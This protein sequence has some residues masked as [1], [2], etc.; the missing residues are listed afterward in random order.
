MRLQFS[1]A[2]RDG[3]CGAPLTGTRRRIL[4]VQLAGQAVGG[5]KVGRPSS[6]CEDAAGRHRWLKRSLARWWPRLP[7]LQKF[8]K[9]L[10][11]TRLRNGL[12]LGAT[13]SRNE[14]PEIRLHRRDVRIAGRC[15]PLLRRLEAFPAFDGD[16]E[17]DLAPF[18]IVRRLADFLDP[19]Q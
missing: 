15:E 11:G 10:V 12:A 13:L 9:Q 2:N 16:G 3:T 7:P 8:L 1:L 19:S 17:I 6:R 18:R 14:L 5:H 4:P